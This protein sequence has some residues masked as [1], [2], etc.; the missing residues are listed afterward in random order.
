MSVLLDF[1]PLLLLIESPVID[2]KN[3]YQINLEKSIYVY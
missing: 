3:R 1:L 2:E